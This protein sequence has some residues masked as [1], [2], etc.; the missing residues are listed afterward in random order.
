MILGKK[1][2]LSDLLEVMEKLRDPKDGC[3]WD[4]EQSS[5]SLTPY[6]IEEA[7]E[8]V[9]ALGKGDPEQTCDELG[10]L[11]LQIVFQAQIAKEEG[12]FDMERIISKATDK[13]IRRHPHIFGSQKEKKTSNEQKVSWEKIKEKER[14][15]RGQESSPFVISNK[16]LPAI[17]EARKLQNTASSLGLDFKELDA[18]ISSI[19]EDL[20]KFK[21]AVKKRSENKIK[22]GLGELLFSLINLSRKLELDPEL[23]LRDANEK[24]SNQCLEYFKMKKDFEQKNTSREGCSP[25]STWESIKAKEN[26]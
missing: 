20:K 9:E 10:D 3:Q 18:P 23:S 22:S 26:G 8:L 16:S 4:L 5:A 19:L 13:M 21:E 11:L 14:L 17:N 25:I 24:F 15:D 7:Y 6:I 12:L 2:P 1:R